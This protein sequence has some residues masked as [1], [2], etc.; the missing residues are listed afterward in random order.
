[1][2]AAFATYSLCA[3]VAMFCAA[4]LMRAWARNRSPLLLKAGIAFIF[5]SVSNLLLVV[6]LYSKS[7]LSLPRAV[8]VAIGLG[9]LSSGLIAEQTR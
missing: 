2:T 7:D 3:L 6:D 5:L 1:M 4:L 8:L 9:V